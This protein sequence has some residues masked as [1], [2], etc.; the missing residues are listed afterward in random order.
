MTMTSLVSTGS[1][2]SSSKT[3]FV[4]NLSIFV[5]EHD[6]YELFLPFGG[7]ESIEFKKTVDREVC[8]CFVKFANYETA[9]SVLITLD[10]HIFQG[11]PLR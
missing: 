7:V 10:G 9:K 6:F 8:Y 11:K 5:H 3:L 2:T 4:G 1:S